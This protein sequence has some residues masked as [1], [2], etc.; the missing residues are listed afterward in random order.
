MRETPVGIYLNRSVLLPV[1]LLAVLKAG[2]AC[3][4]L[5]LD[6]PV[7]RI[8]RMIDDLHGPLVLTQGE[9]IGN[10]RD[11][12]AKLAL[13]SNDGSN[14]GVEDGPYPPSQV[15]A[16]HLAYI[17][18]TSGSTGKPRGVELT[19]AGLVNHNLAAIQLYGLKPSDRVLQFSSLSFDI[20]LEEIF[21]TWIAG[22]TLVMRSDDFSLVPADFSRWISENKIS[23]L[24]LPTAYWHEWIH[25][26]ADLGL[27]L[28]VDLRLVILGG[29]K[30]SLNTFAVWKK[31]AKGKV[32]LINTYGPTETSVIATAYEPK[33]LPE[34]EL[35]SVL[36]IGRPIANTSIYILDA[37]RLPV[38]V[39]V[40][41]EIY[42][43][44]LG[45]ARGYRERLD[46]TAEKFI[47][48]PFGTDS[49]GRLYKTGDLARFLPDGNIEF[50]GRLDNQVKI[51]GFRVERGEI[52]AALSQHPRIQQC[53]VAVKQDTPGE[54]KLVAYCVCSPASNTNTRELWSFLKAKLPDYMLPSY[55]VVL[56]RLPLTPNGKVDDNALP[57]PKSQA[58]TFDEHSMAPQTPLHA[59]VAA[60][61]SEILRVHPLGIHEN[62]FEL[63]GHSLLAV[64]VI[65]KLR[66]Q[67]GLELSLRTLF[68][69]PTV[70]ELC[71][72]IES[73]RSNEESH[74]VPIVAVRRELVR[75]KRSHS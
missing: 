64:Q 39:G 61:W 5:D 10:L 44:G 46:M 28:P 68:E 13:L 75:V 20:A 43:G 70:S 54:T 63:G 32:R 25:D 41:G 58:R 16:E 18:F 60:V 31:L 57:I 17:I 40:P 7:E 3:V 19:H 21:P 24:D 26:I 59:A 6:Y 4:P 27:P 8:A 30:A 34:D 45:V 12:G 22:G 65:S 52:E 2:G 9:L 74:D 15:A 71:V 67:L 51:R 36:P 1:A 55:F 35:P 48:D 73:Y 50:L 66:K 47:A 53:Y 49:A 33:A 23:V 42:I 37:D 56:E 14:I 38:P 69:N 62:F 72:S 11:T 29:E